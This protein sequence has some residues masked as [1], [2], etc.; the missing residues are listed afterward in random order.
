M[1]AGPPAPEAVLA[2][3]VAALRSWAPAGDPL[4]AVLDDAERRAAGA[5]PEV[6]V[7]DLVVAA[8]DLAGSRPDLAAAAAAPPGA[9]DRG[10]A[11]HRAAG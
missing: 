10:E 4:Q 7:L 5:A 3:L 6:L 9:A 1:P 11:A 8:D 2:D